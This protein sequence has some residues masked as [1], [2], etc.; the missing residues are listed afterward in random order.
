MFTVA[1]IIVLQSARLQK[2]NVSL[3]DIARDMRNEALGGTGG[4]RQKTQFPPVKF[5]RSLGIQPGDRIGLSASYH[6]GPIAITS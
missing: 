5:A 1:L 4:L 2:K 6:Y 3:A